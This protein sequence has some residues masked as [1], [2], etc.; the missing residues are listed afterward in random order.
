[1]SDANIPARPHK[2]S[3]DKSCDEKPYG[4]VN[5]QRIDH[6][7]AHAYVHRTMQFRENK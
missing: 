3:T 6:H 1:M 5:S 7:D 4:V 2:Q